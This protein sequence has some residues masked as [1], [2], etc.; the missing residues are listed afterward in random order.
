MPPTAADAAPRASAQASAGRYTN[1]AIALHWV[2]AVLIGVNLVLVWFAGKWPEGWVRPA[3]D[4]HKS[5]GVSVLGLVLMRILWRWTH[6]PPPLPADY[7]KLEKAAAH[8]AHIALYLLILAIPLSGWL[9]DSAWKDGP[10]HPDKLFWL[11]PWPRVW[12]LADLPPAPKEHA[13]A[14]WF[15]VHKWA[16]YGLYGLF[17]LHVAAALKHQW[18]DGE[19]ELQ[20]MAPGRGPP[21]A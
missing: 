8:M 19:P 1:T 14:V 15:A 17:G 4:L 13:H 20:R 7:P 12:L 16:A 2:I 10:T 9:H 6:K 5:I 18:I 11:V 21:H 3:I